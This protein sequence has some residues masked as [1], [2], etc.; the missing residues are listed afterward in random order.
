MQKSSKLLT[1][2][3]NVHEVLYSPGR[4]LDPAIR[5]FMEISPG[6]DFSPVRMGAAMVEGTQVSLAVSQPGDIFEQ[7]AGSKAEQVMRGTQMQ[8][9]PRTSAKRHD[10]SQVRVHT[11]ALAAESARAVGALAYTVGNHAAWNK[12]RHQPCQTRRS[13]ALRV[14]VFERMLP[15][16]A[17]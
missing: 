10:F 13:P 15:S 1:V 4:P 17:L 8:P 11:G 5:E 7:E 14:S 12:P 16:V 3:P 9:G 6:R 2:P